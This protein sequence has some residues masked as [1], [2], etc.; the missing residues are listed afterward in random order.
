MTQLGTLTWNASWVNPF[1]SGWSILEKIKYANVINTR[2]LLHEFEFD[3]EN[4]IHVIGF[5]FLEQSKQNLT[6]LTGMFSKITYINYLIRSDLT[7]CEECLSM[8]HHSLFHQ[9]SLLHQCPFHLCDLRN[10]CSK[11]GRKI[12][13]NFVNFQTFEGFT[14]KCSELIT[15]L[16]FKSLSEWQLHVPIKD[17][18]LIKW[19]EIDITTASYLFKNDFFYFP[20]LIKEPGAMEFILQYYDFKRTPLVNS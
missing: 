13:F 19:L 4:L 10:A 6:R 14:C 18:L 20:Q 17:E 9:F 8:G 7:Y 11:C 12:T 1:E 16:N 3:L 2:D 5:D 15:D